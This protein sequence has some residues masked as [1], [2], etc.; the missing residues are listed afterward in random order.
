MNI[1]GRNV[2]IEGRN[3]DIQSKFM[4]IWNTI[5]MNAIVIG[6][7]GAGAAQFSADPT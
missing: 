7:Y 1:W 6:V 3:I 4:N 5:G 2:D